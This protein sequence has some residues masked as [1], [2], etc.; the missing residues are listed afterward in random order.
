[1]SCLVVN[2]IVLI[3][4]KGVI[5]TNLQAFY[6]SYR[7]RKTAAGQVPLGAREWIP[8]ARGAARQW[9][10]LKLGAAIR[11][12]RQSASTAA[13][14]HIAHMPVPNGFLN[15]QGQLNARFRKLVR[16]LERDDITRKLWDRLAVFNDAEHDAV[17]FLVQFQ[18]VSR[19]YLNIL[20]GNIAEAFSIPRQ[21][22]VLERYRDIYPNAVLITGLKARFQGQGARRLFTDNIIGTFSQDGNLVVHHVFEIKAG[23]NGGLAG[24]EQ[25][26]RWDHR[27]EQGV[28]LL[29]PGDADIFR[30]PRSD[31]TVGILRTSARQHMASR[32]IRSAARVGDD[33]SFAHNI[34]GANRATSLRT[35]D[36]EVVTAL[37][38]SV[39]SPSGMSSAGLEH[40]SSLPTDVERLPM[41]MQHDE[42]DY[43]VRYLLLN[44]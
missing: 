34:E 30:M 2:D 19:G 16:Y 26:V 36:R 39:I 35:A 40:L 44:R 38:Q 28:E 37:G 22:L 20:K 15:A 18:Q 42:M 43:L 3:S 25:V 5:N 29:I 12:I 6:T 8:R 32:R 31:Q 41:G 11:Q 13:K 14:I 21:L 7:A 10:E 33:F 23:Y 4:D 9:L 17:R 1:M 24:T 27:I